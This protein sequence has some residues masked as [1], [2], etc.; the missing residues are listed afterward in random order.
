MLEKHKGSPD[1]LRKLGQDMAVNVAGFL[2]FVNAAPPGA[3]HYAGKDVKLGTPDRPILWMTRK[4]DGRSIVVYADL[5][6]KEVPAEEVPKLP[7]TED[8]SKP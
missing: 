8:G 4:K 2:G 3:L 7:E 1:Q 6:V 5:K